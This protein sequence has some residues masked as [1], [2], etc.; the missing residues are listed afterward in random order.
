MVFIAELPEGSITLT[1]HHAHFT[2]GEAQR[3]IVTFLGDN[4]CTKTCRA[5]KLSTATEGELNVVDHQPKGHFLQRQS[6]A[7]LDGSIRSADHGGPYGQSLRSN[8]VAL[9]AVGIEYQG[10]VCTAVRIVFDSLD[11][12]GNAVLV[13]LEIDNTICTLMA[14]ASTANTDAPESI[15]TSLLGKADGQGLLRLAGSQLAEDQSSL[16]AKAGS[17][18]LVSF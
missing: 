10:N 3:Y 17:I 5:D 18:G 1:E 7:A 13:A 2:G 14:T 16:L 9:L 6:I 11:S 8:H 15:P 12:S 4:G